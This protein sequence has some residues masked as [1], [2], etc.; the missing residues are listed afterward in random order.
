MIAAQEV[1]L[2]EQIDEWFELYEEKQSLNG[3][4]SKIKKKMKE[5][6]VKLH[7]RLEGGYHP[8]KLPNGKYLVKTIRSG[9][10]SFV[11]AWAK[12]AFTQSSDMAGVKKNLEKVKGWLE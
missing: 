8:V 9:G 10:G 2:N 1:D 11:K 5:I 12:P 3:Q 7:D 6:E 4:L